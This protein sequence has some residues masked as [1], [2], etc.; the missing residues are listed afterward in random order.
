MDE[1]RLL[2]HVNDE[3]LMFNT[4]LEAILGTTVIYQK[5]GKNYFQN[6]RR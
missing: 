3:A 2:L 4:R 5:N 6:T 1:M